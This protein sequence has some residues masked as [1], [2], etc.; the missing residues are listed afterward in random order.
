L[1][2]DYPKMLQTKFG[3]HPSIILVGDDD[4]GFFSIFSFSGLFVAFVL[5][6]FI[7]FFHGMALFCHIEGSMITKT[8][9][10]H[11]GERSRTC[12]VK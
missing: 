2:K 5:L 10:G 12:N 11:N 1:I 6:I 7:L 3:D 4:Q 8:W 9:S